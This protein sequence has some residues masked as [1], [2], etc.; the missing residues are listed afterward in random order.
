MISPM[1]VL[2]YPEARKKILPFEKL[3]R[4]VNPLLLEFFFVGFQDIAVDRLFSSTD[5]YSQRS[6]EIFLMIPS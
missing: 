5:S 2:K 6:Y 4:A 3:A 1:F